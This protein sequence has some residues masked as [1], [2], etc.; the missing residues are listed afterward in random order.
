MSFNKSEK[1]LLDQI[2]GSRV[3]SDLLEDKISDG[4][5]SL[6]NTIWA[7]SNAS[8]AGNGSSGRPFKSLQKAVDAASALGQGIRKIIFVAA[9]SAFD[10]DVVVNNGFLTIMGLG[11]FTLG[12]ADLDKWKS[13]TP[14]NFTYNATLPN[15]MQDRWDGLVLGTIMDD[16]A[17]STHTA[18]MNGFTISGDCTFNNPSGSSKNLQLRNVKVEGEFIQTGTQSVQTYLRRCYFVNSF[19]G[20][21]N[22][23][24][25]IADSCEFNELITVGAHGRIWQCQIQGGLTTGGLTAALPPSG[26]YETDFTGTFTGP[27]GSFVLDAVTNYFFNNNITSLA[28][29]ATKVLLHDLTL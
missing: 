1:K 27:A 18:A 2:A 12:A 17:S 6:S 7:D 26:I 14:R 3:G 19:T 25:N 4:G 11:P 13:S 10:E 8:T 20:D 21:G 28:G 29:G 15:T 9:G 5:V 23:Q 24:L 22:M 16:E